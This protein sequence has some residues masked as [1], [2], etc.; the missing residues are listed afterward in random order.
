ME[1]QRERSKKAERDRRL[2]Q[3]SRI[4]IE[5]IERDLKNRREKTERLRQARLAVETEGDKHDQAT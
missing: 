4:A 1:Q 3:T 5:M 2:E